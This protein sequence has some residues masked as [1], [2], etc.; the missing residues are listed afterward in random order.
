MLDTLVNDDDAIWLRQFHELNISQ[1]ILPFEKCL[2]LFLCMKWLCCSQSTLIIAAFYSEFINIYI[3][4]STDRISKT[5]AYKET[6]ITLTSKML[7]HI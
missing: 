3:Y 5:K 7:A 4:T 1:S 6:L 2:K